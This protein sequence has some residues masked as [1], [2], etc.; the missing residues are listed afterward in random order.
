[1]VTPFTLEYTNDA[2]GDVITYTSDNITN[3]NIDFSTPVSPMPLPQMEDKE[4]ILIKVEGNT[5][6]AN[7]SWKIRDRDATPFSGGAPYNA[8]DTA[9]EQILIFKDNFVPVDVSDSYILTIG[10]TIVLKGTLM[11]MSFAISGTSPV[12]WDGSFQFVHGNVASS[13][14][15][16]LADAPIKTNNSAILTGQD[17]TSSGHKADIPQIMTTYFGVDEGIT[18]YTVK[19]KLSSADS[20]TLATTSNIAYSQS[21]T[22]ADQQTL[23]IDVGSAG[24]YDFRVAATTTT[25]PNG[26]KWS[27]VIENVT[28]A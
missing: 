8:A 13:Q 23:T 21:Q 12:V 4:N 27:N 14:D 16:L 19:Y 9:M 1:M 5:T 10:D 20:W 6:T 26:N 3:I 11:K 15:A 25:N 18:G 28:V 17:N 22:N 7:I 24:T 2:T